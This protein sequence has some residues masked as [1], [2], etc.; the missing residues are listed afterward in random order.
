MK[1][2]GSYELKVINRV[3]IAKIIGAWNKEEGEKYFSELKRIT[4][5]LIQSPWAM[6]V[7]IDE[8]QLGTP[9]SDEVTLELIQ[10]LASHKLQLVAEIYSPNVLKKMHIQRMVNSSKSD[11]NR[12]YF[13]DDKDAFSWLETQG[14][15]LNSD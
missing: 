4:R 12:Q 2:H 13:S 14:F 5:D 11:I 10:W 9:G 3:L 6:V 15:S 7:Y 1:G 8:W